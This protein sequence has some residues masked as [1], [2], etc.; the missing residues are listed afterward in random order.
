[1]IKPV[2]GKVKS[3]SYALP[4]DDHVY[5][6][7]SKIDEE[8]A[9]EV[10]QSWAQSKSSEPS[11]MQSFPATT[12]LALKNGCLT[13]KS[14]SEYGKQNP[15]MKHRYETRHKVVVDTVSANQ[16]SAVTQ[17]PSQEIFGIQSKENEVSMTELLRC[18]PSELE[19]ERD[20]PD[21]SGKKRKGSLPPAKATKS[22]LSVAKCREPQSEEKQAKKKAVGEFKLTK[23]KKVES[24]VKKYMT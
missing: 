7:E 23:F 4:D 19:D 21:L 8:N 5:G 11:S 10:V 15:V 20:Y 12:R 13:S 22:S 18:I 6:I 9:G 16:D 1:M 3:P 24:I 2:V 17:Q 14:Q